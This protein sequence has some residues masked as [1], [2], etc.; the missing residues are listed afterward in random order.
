MF[1]P[2]PALPD[3]MSGRRQ[4][5]YR[6]GDNAAYLARYGLSRFSFVYDVP[7]QEDFGI[8]FF[9]TLSI[10]R[11]RF[12]YP[13]IPF[14]VQVKS[15]TSTIILDKD[16]LT[17]FKRH[18]ASPFLICV[19][20][21]QTGKL[22][23]YSCTLIWHALASCYQAES[24]KL[25]I[26][27]EEFTH[28]Q[29]PHQTNGAAT[30]ARFD[31]FIGPPVFEATGVELD[32]DDGLKAHSALSPIL[33]SD[34]E[35]IINIRKGQVTTTH[36]F[37]DRQNIAYFTGPTYR[38]AEYEIINTLIGLVANYIKYNQHERLNA[39]ISYLNTLNV[40]TEEIYES[41]QGLYPE[42]LTDGMTAIGEPSKST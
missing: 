13:E 14:N 37:N 24:I 42:I 35:S 5:S 20:D 18:M 2:P 29:N 6:C 25:I 39:I 22:Y 38:K 1:G 31:I 30:N 17:F 12:V 11:G 3:N 36:Y 26:N 19:V 9:C 27:R 32:A 7:Y 34:Q 4:H 10:K 28:E 33:Q 23:F 8:D 15:N 16:L 41:L 21:Q 40:T